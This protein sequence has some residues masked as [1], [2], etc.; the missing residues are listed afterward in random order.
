MM[1]VEHPILIIGNGLAGTLL[2][3]AI[4]HH[5]VR[6]LRIGLT[7][8]GAATRAAYGIINPIHIRTASPAWMAER[9]VPFALKTYA[10][11]QE[12]IN[13]PFYFPT[14]IRHYYRNADDKRLWELNYESSETFNWVTPGQDF[15]TIHSAAYVNA[16]F[17][18]D[19]AYNSGLAPCRNEVFV[20]SE[21]TQVQ[22]GWSYRGELYSAVIFAE[23]WRAGT[24]P[25]F[26]KLPLKP[27]KGQV[28]E[29]SGVQQHSE[30]LIHK[31]GFFW[32]D[33]DGRGKVGSTYN[34]RD[35]S[36]TVNELDTQELIKM[37]EELV[38]S[39]FRLS[40]VHVGIR[41]AS[42]DRRPILGEH[43]LYPGLF[44]FN[45]LGSRG[46]SL[47]PYFAE[48]LVNHLLRNIEVYPTVE[49]KRFSKRLARRSD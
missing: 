42:G 48:Q 33:K 23:G 19:A 7:Q 9:V 18:V 17:F 8:D 27:N 12:R 30:G 45:G 22:D 15:V 44:I 47:G 41:P 14:Q 3:L 32:G 29:I 11:L 25:W 21:L 10:Q 2:H 36:S 13:E 24:N 5:P 26:N 1:R 16:P 35:V 38:G 49:V 34:N 6:V 46:L 43:P 20:Y 37:A 4:E 39:D 28:L 31:R 40:A